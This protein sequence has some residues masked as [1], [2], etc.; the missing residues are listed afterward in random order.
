MHQNLFGIFLTLIVIHAS[1]VTLHA[2]D[3]HLPKDV[4][5]AFGKFATAIKKDQYDEAARWIAPP[6][7]QVWANYGVARAAAAKYHS[8]MITRFGTV[9]E[10]PFEELTAKDYLVSQ[11]HEAL[12]EI[13][14][15]KSVGKDMNRIHV[16]VWTKKDNQRKR[17][18]SAIYERVFTAVKSKDVWKFELHTFRGTPVVKIVKRIAVDGKEVE[19][20]AEHSTN[21][22]AAEK[23][24]VE[25]KPISYEN[26]EAELKKEAADWL[27]TA[28][29]LGLQAELV[30]KGMF[31]SQSEAH[32][33][34]LDVLRKATQIR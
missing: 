20:Y 32:R 13:Q 12:G 14:N 11:F 5:E 8:A 29:I 18:E 1:N 19:V 16:C 31:K 30:R 9:G 21:G 26:R 23:N 24:W 4:V 34:T 17:T 25:L 2:D 33:N 15:V 7:D 27:K 3:R 28:E 10:S 22:S 6:A